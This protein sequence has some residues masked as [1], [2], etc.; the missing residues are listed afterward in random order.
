MSLYTSA[1]RTLALQKLGFRNAHL[2]DNF[3]RG[4]ALGAPLTIDG[5]YGPKTDAALKL[6]VSR[7]AKGQGTASANFSFTEFRC[8]C[9]GMVGCQGVWVLAGHLRRLEAARTKTGTIH[10][11]SG[12]RCPSYNARIGGAS[13]S[14]HLFGAASDVAFPDKDTVRSWQLFAGVGYSQ[15]SDKCLHVDSRDLSGHNQTGGK[16][17][18]PTTWRYA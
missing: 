7:L 15:S 3:Q 2:I 8:K 16:P 1:Q 12:C 13:S 6:S 17:S 9:G 4:W 5:K 11:V 18:A 10:I 14:Q